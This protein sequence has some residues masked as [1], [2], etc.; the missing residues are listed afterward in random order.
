[1]RFG[2]RMFADVEIAA[3]SGGGNDIYRTIARGG[4]VGWGLWGG[5]R[6]EIH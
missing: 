3:V 5:A 4:E 2:D 1:M 6:G